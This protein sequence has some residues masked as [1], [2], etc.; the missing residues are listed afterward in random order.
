MTGYNAIPTFW[1][2]HTSAERGMIGPLLM[3]GV[4]IALIRVAI[5]TRQRWW[6]ALVGI[7]VLLQ[8]YGTYGINDTT[9]EMLIT[10]GGDG[11]GMVL[12]TTLMST[13]YLGKETQLYKGSVRWGLL[14]WGAAAF[15][16]IFMAWWEGQADI[17]RVG[18]GTSGGNYSDAYLLINAYAWNW[19]EMIDRHLRVGYFCLLLQATMYALGLWQARGWLQQ[20]EKA[21]T[22]ARVRAKNA[23]SGR[24]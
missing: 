14:F 6:Y 8:W 12:V 10:F 3:I 9:A 24:A 11:M 7:L 15:M 2:T 17:A 13:F 23:A 16:D 18:Y 5:A 19:G 1:V 20:H 22:V 21:E 4:Y